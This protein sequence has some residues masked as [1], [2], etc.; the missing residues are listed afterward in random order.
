MRA[1]IT[2]LAVALLST[3]PMGCDLLFPCRPIAPHE[4]PNGSPP[5]EGVGDD[6][7]VPDGTRWGDGPNEVLETVERTASDEPFSQD[8]GLT[9]R[10]NPAGFQ[11][12][13]DAPVFAPPDRP[14]LIWHE[15]SCTYT[16]ILDPSLQDPQVIDYAG[17]F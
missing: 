14:A 8:P 13:A 12:V 4:L 11:S 3:V 2:M 16:V 7:F 10:G 15:G 1:L 17:R 5:G 6:T 9:V